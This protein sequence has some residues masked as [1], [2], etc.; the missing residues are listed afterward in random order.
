MADGVHS[1][2]REFLTPKG[3]VDPLVKASPS[4]RCRRGLL[5]RL[6]DAFRLQYSPW[7]DKHR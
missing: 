4:F 3:Q 7:R 6:L 1:K 2:A 5:T